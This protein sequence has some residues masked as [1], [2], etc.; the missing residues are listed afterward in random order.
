MIATELHQWAVRHGVTMQALFEL[1]A[2]VGAAGDMADPVPGVPSRAEA[3]VQDAVRLE[4]KPRGCRLFRNNVGALKDIR[5]V[6]V[7]YGLANDSPKINEKLKSSDLI[8]WR[9]L[10]ITPAH[11]G[12]VVAQFVSRECKPQGWHW[13]GTDREVA[14]K[15][16]LDLVTVE[17]GDGKFTTGPGTL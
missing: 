14:Q 9:R 6:P 1:S 15:A 8:G 2:L 7:R 13:T 3:W 4:A 17:G 11:V 5:G 10:L 12:H 16:W